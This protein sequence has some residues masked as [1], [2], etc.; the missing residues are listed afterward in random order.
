MFVDY[1]NHAR[2]NP[3]LPAC[4]LFMSHCEQSSP[5]VNETSSS[6]RIEL[7][8]IAV[9]RSNQSPG[10]HSSKWAGVRIQIHK[11]I[12]MRPILRWVQSQKGGEI[13]WEEWM[14]KEGELRYH[15]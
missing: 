12:L 13:Y 14:I 7:Q 2:N 15:S 9:Y 4:V 1:E 10:R 6:C 11:A 8:C 5:N 3:I